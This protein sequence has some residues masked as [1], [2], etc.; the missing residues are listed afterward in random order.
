MG[1]VTM[2]S[3][4]LAKSV[5]DL[6]QVSLSEYRLIVFFLEQHESFTELLKFCYFS[7]RIYV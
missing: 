6:V 2:K 7:A 4:T 3:K 5:V 1:S